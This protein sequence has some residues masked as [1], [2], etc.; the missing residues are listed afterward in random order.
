M[1]I[2]YAMIE[3]LRE[4]REAE[5]PAPAPDLTASSPKPRPRNSNG[6]GHDARLENHPDGV[7]LLA[8]AAVATAYFLDRNQEKGAAAG[9][10]ASAQHGFVMPVPVTAVVK[11][12]I[13]IILDYAARTESI[14]NITLLARVTGYVAAQP[15][16]DGADVKEGDLLYKI[17]PRDLQ[18]A[19]DQ[20]TAQSQ[21][22]AAAL[23]YARANF[24]RGNDLVKSG[25]VDKDTF[26]QRESA[27]R[28][29]EAAITMDQ[30]RSAPRSSIWAMPR[31]ARPSRA[32][33]ATRRR[34][35]R[36]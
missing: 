10:P 30:A 7:V 8:A 2:F 17:D 22:D 23:E 6:E 29:A 13:P 3:R 27:M 11:K 5:K 14:R 21:R 20:I 12:T 28:Q 25:F 31:S 4:G 34:S 1:P 32:L 16:P 24:N 18:A 36:S 33:G 26:H 9:A 19:L 15:A 35:A